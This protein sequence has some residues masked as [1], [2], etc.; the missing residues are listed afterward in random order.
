[1]SSSLTSEQPLEAGQHA[2]CPSSMLERSDSQMQR[3][4][5]GNLLRA[6]I[7]RERGRCLECS[8]AAALAPIKRWPGALVWVKALEELV[9]RLSPQRR[10]LRFTAWRLINLWSILHKH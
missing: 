1:M 8:I 2:I 9:A 4:Q 7:E 3:C 10:V 6:P 5:C